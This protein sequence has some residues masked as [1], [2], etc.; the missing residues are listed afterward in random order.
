LRVE[1]L[2]CQPFANRS[3]EVAFRAVE[4]NLRSIPQDGIAYI[5]TNVAHGLKPGG[6]PDEI[7]MV[8][9]TASGAAV[10]EVKHWEVSRIKSHSYEVEH[11][12]DLV[13]SKAKRIASRFRQL[14]PQFGFVPALM[15]LTKGAKS[16]RRDGQLPKV[17][18][19]RFHGL[20]DLEELTGELSSART[21][22]DPLQLVK[23]IAPRELALAR[24][25]LKR[26]GR[27]VQLKRLSPDDDS[28]R[29]VYSAQDGAGGDKVTIHVYD[30][31]ALNTPNAEQLAR[32]EFDAVQRFQKSPALPSLVDSFQAVPD[33]PGELFFFT[34]AESAAASIAETSA[35]SDWAEPARLAFAASAFHELAALQRPTADGETL[36]HRAL[37]SESVRVRADGRPLFAGWRWARLPK[38]ETIAGNHPDAAGDSYAAPEVRAHGLATADIRSDV[39]SLCT[40]LL[41]LF[42]SGS[43]TA[44]AAGDILKR[45]LSDDPPARPSAEEIARALGQLAEPPVPPNPP[46]L[47][48]RWDEGAIIDWNHERFRVVS[49]LGEGAAG[50]TFKL[51]Q[52]D[53]QSDEPI[54]TFVG[55]VVLNEQFGASALEA[56]RKVRAIA[57]HPALSGVYQTAQEWRPDSLVALLKWRPGEPLDNWRGEYLT[58]LADE[59]NDDGRA[60]PEALLLAWAELI[61][62][63]LN[64]FHA[65]NWVHGDV[66]L[67]NILVQE[68][69]ACLIDFDLARPAG[70]VIPSPGTPIYA[71]PSRRA[72]QPAHLS[73]DI[74][75]LAASL[76]HALTDR[77]PFLFGGVRRD[78]TG[79]AWAVD[80]QDRFP[81]FAQ[82]ADRACAADPNRRFANAA[83]ALSA[84]R[85]QDRGFSATSHVRRDDV[86]PQPL[87]P[88][89][90][91]RVIE[92]LRSYPGSRFGNAET[93]GLDSLFAHDTYVETGLDRLLPKAILTGQLGLVI[94]CGNAGD[95]KTA[96][97][98]H[99]AMT[100]GI[101]DL[102]S[103]RRVHEAVVGGMT[104]KINLDG[105]ASWNGKSADDLLDELF[106]PFH[107]GPQKARVHLV[108]VND[109]RL[110]EWVESYERRHSETRLTAQIVDALGREGS[111]LDAHIRLIE[112][113][114]RSL[115]GG[116]EPGGDRVSTDFID[117]MISKLVGGES[118]PEIWQPCQSCTAQS[119]CSIRQSAFMMGASDD[120]ALLAQGTLLRRRLTEALQAVHQRN[121]V[122]IT[123]RELKAALSYILFGIYGCQDLHDDVSIG[124]HVPADFA[125]DP[126]SPRRQGELLRELTRLD[127]AL[128]AH[129]RIDR[130]LVRAAPPDPAHGA[131]RFPN[132]SL[133]SARR[134]AL[135]MWSDDQITM[136]GGNPSALGLHEGRHFADFRNFPLLSG[137]RQ[138]SIR[139]EICRGLS[140]LEALPD[141]AFKQANFCPVRVVPRTPTETS[142]WVAK[143]LERFGLE[144][145]KFVGT[146][147][148]ETLH[149]HLVLSYQMWRGSEERLIV[150]LNLFT[151]LREL[152]DGVQILD[153]F[154]D[155]VFANLG[156]FTQRLAQEDERLLQ[157]WNPADEEHIFS[158]SA[159]AGTTGQ[160]IV[161]RPLRSES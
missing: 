125:F 94:L 73:D 120:P 134:Q 98:Q 133:R 16:L 17:R 81:S 45:G 88:M 159:E 147:G 24:G 123:A 146:P 156:I 90:V 9:L 101:A 155:D 99:L 76:F 3:E 18:G 124:K 33:Y 25:E 151:M 118:T 148:L 65:Q 157:A 19:V 20:G 54:G 130:Y 64:V 15:M 116:I 137:E 152:A 6:Q 52:L 2:P 131:P 34:L 35:D 115:V 28:F 58:L 158:V 7:D 149:R 145:E 63:G 68:S 56:Y 113:N 75:A 138:R 111:G 12:A 70:S 139:D 1:H 132:V 82:F 48:Q 14:Y 100:L 42:T 103:D 121:E 109:G 74:F 104:I 55:K 46:E 84:L 85:A 107:S 39:Y 106:E 11:H 62:E 86:G 80:E 32:R 78:D 79:L 40:T 59:I 89:I 128:D 77:P 41:E 4:G 122:H 43:T 8:V 153:A 142:F 143:S 97:L 154:S 71:S 67:S 47:P 87:R 119:R 22:V 127:P 136:V 112:L 5:L 91:P 144:S 31:S 141:I 27:Y 13:T 105:A 44:I 92:I 161:L 10:I 140:R 50:R 69:N 129:A 21:G 110:M 30:L 83:E 36:V 95:G 66:S 26:L 51:E 135:F 60:Q 53:G 108:A 57:D 23:A 96:L 126:G 117:E 37:T 38:S 49:R 61:C 29:R 102:R 114:F 93:R 72:L 150:P 160:M